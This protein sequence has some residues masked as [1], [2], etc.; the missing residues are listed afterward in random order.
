MK[1]L[2]PLFLL[3]LSALSFGACDIYVDDPYYEGGY[4][5][6]RSRSQTISGQWQGD[7]GM[8]YRAENPYTRNWEQFDADYSYVVFHSD[9]YGAR[10]GT[11]K[12]VDFY[13]YGPYEYQYHAFRWEVNRG[14][15][16]ID[17]PH[18]RNLNVEIYDYALTPYNFRGR[19]NGSN[20][21]FNLTKLNNWN[22]WHYFTGNYMNGELNSWNW[23]PFYAPKTRAAEADTPTAPLAIEHG[24]RTAALTH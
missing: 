1:K 21:V 13:R 5:G 6:D 17:Y 15:L 24:R 9:Y 22:R 11:G 8:F 12:Q 10:S 16:Y 18:D 19:I 20:F 23:R 14:V 2:F 4:H 3:L 7:F